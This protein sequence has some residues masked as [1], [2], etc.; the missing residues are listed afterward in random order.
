MHEE[1]LRGGGSL[2][3]SEMADWH[4]RDFRDEVGPPSSACHLQAVRRRPV[5][6]QSFRCRQRRLLMACDQYVSAKDNS[7][8][9]PSVA[10]VTVEAPLAPTALACGVHKPGSLS[11]GQ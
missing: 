3:S 8:V 9:P 7:V 2:L 5:G 6:Q 1:G 4:K 11:V 10:S